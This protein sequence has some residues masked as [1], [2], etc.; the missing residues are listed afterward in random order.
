VECPPATGRRGA[1]AVFKVRL[2]RS[3]RSPLLLRVVKTLYQL[4]DSVLK[5]VIKA[6]KEMALADFK[7]IF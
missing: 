1:S 5:E 2:T 6:R 7:V 4:D 3:G